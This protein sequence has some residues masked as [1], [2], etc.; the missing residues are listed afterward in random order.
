MDQDLIKQVEQL[1]HVPAIGANYHIA[2]QS[3]LDDANALLDDLNAKEK[4]LEAIKEKNY[5][6]ARKALDDLRTFFNKPI[7]AVQSVKEIVRKE[8][9]R[10]IRAEE[11]KRL[12]IAR[13][14]EAKR[15]AELVKLQEK[16][17]KAR[18]EGRT[19]AAD[20]AERKMVDVALAP[21][22]IPA[23]IVKPDGINK[24]VREVGK[25]GFVSANGEIIAEPDMTII[26]VAYHLL[27]TAALNSAAKAPGPK[28][29]I[30]GIYFYKD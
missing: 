4:Q 7:E 2:T 12:A 24:F 16:A 10:Y 19:K 17:D 1:G 29:K 6:P 30:P 26:P 5:T 8:A 21:A 15:Q 23:A 13:E 20:N 18:E 3:D 9:K 14:E 28:P 22:L 11:E 27:N 25:Y